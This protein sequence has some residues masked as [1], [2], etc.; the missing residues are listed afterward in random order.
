MFESSPSRTVSLSRPYRLLGIAA[1]V[2]LFMFAGMLAYKISERQGFK[3]LRDEA[4]H[5]LDILASAID[6]QVTR[7]AAIPAAVLLSPDVLALLR[8]PEEGKDVL[9]MAANRFLQ[10]LNDNLGGP[11]IFVLDTEGKVIASSDWI[12]T[13]NMLGE[14]LSYMPFFRGAVAG[15]PER[16][17]AVDHVRN[18]PGYFFALP[19]LDELQ[20]WKV[21]GVAVVKSGLHE[22]ERRWLAQKEPALIVDPNGIALLAT[23]P[24]WRYASLQPLSPEALARIGREQF[25]GLPVG[26]SKL[27]IPMDAAQEGA[28]VHLGLPGVAF[29][30]AKSYLALSRHLSGTA[31]RI[32][33]FSDLK[34]VAV[35]AATHA[36]LTAAALGCLLLWLLYQSQ[37]RRLA[38]G[39]EE[40][41]AMLEM[42]NQALERNVAERTVDLS[43]AVSRLQSEVA[44]RQRAE[45]TL[46][47]A[48]DEL[49]QAAKLAVLGQMAT[50]IT[51]E[52][53]QPIGAISTLSANAVEFMRRGDL[54]TAEKNLAIVGQLSAQ[55]GSIIAPLKTFARKSPAVSAAV[56]VAQAV[57]SALFLFDQ[58]LRKQNVAVNRKIEPNSWIAWCDQN[59]LQQVLVNLIGNAIDAMDEAPE[60]QLNFSIELA[61]SGQLALAVSDSGAGFSERALEHLFEPFFTTKQAGEGLGLGLAISRDILRDFGGNLLAGPAPGG[62][63]RFVVLL[64]PVP[65]IN[66]S[67]D[68]G[69]A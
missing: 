68:K 66:S 52:L 14:D 39:R 64:P 53:S 55:L 33:V 7:H 43:E 69:L 17:Y 40:A 29:P 5:Q 45:Q 49:I 8:A 3:H 30:G 57:D 10:K 44:E 11:A 2:L 63:A 22:L 26:A 16:H 9:Q 47:A 24:E 59:R 54:I 60:R 32:V 19:I 56:D 4:S 6:S 20:G 31:W 28:I 38:R 58:R 41:R 50:G 12:F 36:A 23:P 42:A 35:Q 34:S 27:D 65:A 13:H 67:P 48:Q 21:I 15:V 61:S 37:R 46:R 25:A 51:H 18:E 1:L 62:G